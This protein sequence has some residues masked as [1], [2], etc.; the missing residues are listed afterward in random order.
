MK[1]VIIP[2]FIV[3]SIFVVLYY[4]SFI[5][6]LNI[7]NT[8][9]D[10]SHGYLI[11]PISLYL[12]WRKKSIIVNQPVQPTNLGLIPMVL[13]ACLYFIGIIGQV[14]TFVY[15]SQILFLIGVSLFIA[16]RS[17]TKAILFPI[18]FLVFMYPIPSEIYVKLTGP[19]KLFA[20]TYS[21][22]ILSILN[23]PVIQEGNL[24][25]LPEYS[26][27]VVEACSGLRSLLSVIALSFL[28]GYLFFE[29][30]LY[31][32]ILFILSVPIAIIGNISR[33]VVT[34]LLAYHVSPAYAEGF[35][36]TMAGL[37]A[38]GV[39]LLILYCVVYIIRWIPIK[40][41]L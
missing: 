22:N 17:V 21:V 27:K 33:I 29:S 20:T 9:E 31:R 4:S 26:M 5:D 6:L 3:L 10:Y 2:S 7:W 11:I 35:A 30:Y 1:R 37:M 16:G 12:L 8:Q 19:L 39:S 40:R 38:F 36:H 14:A 24:I 28:I 13:W 34:A 41:D 18:L 23:V 15:V 25:N 32:V